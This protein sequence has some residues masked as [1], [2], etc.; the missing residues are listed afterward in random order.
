[1]RYGVL[2]YEAM[3]LILLLTFLRF[4][5]FF[6]EATRSPHTTNL[7]LDVLFRNPLQF[8]WSQPSQMG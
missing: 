6:Y 5:V 3:G 4:G 2:F 1:M 7:M 8:D